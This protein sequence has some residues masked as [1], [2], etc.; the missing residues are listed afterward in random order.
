MILIDLNFNSR[1]RIYIT[2]LLGNNF[3]FNLMM[4]LGCR[5]GQTAAN[6]LH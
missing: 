6:K 2:K 1:K 5:L 3:Y 4:K